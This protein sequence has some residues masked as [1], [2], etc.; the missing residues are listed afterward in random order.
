MGVR[1]S[2]FIGLFVY[3]FIVNLREGSS[4]WLHMRHLFVMFDYKHLY[5]SITEVQQVSLCIQSPHNSHLF[6]KSNTFAFSRYAAK[7]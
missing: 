3:L 2:F 4:Y 1:G 6:V 7:I 5:A